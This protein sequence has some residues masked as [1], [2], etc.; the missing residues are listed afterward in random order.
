MQTKKNNLKLFVLLFLAVIGLSAYKAA[1]P[2]YLSVTEVSVQTKEKL[3]KVSCKVFID[4]LQQALFDENKKP[5]NLQNNNAVNK[6]L[7][8]AYIISHVS[9]TMGKPITIKF[10][11]YEIE[12][13]AVWCYFEAPLKSNTKDITIQN[14]ILCNTLNGQANIVHCIY[15]SE[16]KSTKLNCPESLA[17]FSF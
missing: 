12:E 11:G 1:H 15:N 16:R 2:F 10:I 9:I 14:N 5:V 7:L 6:D 13:E 4:D 8:S 3:V 17:K